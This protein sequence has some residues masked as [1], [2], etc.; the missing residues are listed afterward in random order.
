[1]SSEQPS[2]NDHDTANDINHFKLCLKEYLKLDDEI[3]TIQAVLRNKKDKF[4]NLSLIL[5]T[6]LENNNINQVQLEGDYKGQELV[7]QKC[8]RTK[9]ISNKSLLE[10]IK[11]KCGDNTELYNSILSEVENQKEIN[12]FSKIKIAKPKKDKYSNA[13]LNLESEETNRLLLNS[14]IRN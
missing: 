9:N 7:S 2:S 13:R 4:E 6:F 12:E 8:S 11:N 10:I 1:M 14:V 3:K 5:L